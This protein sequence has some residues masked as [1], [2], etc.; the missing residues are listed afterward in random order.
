MILK[1][2]FIPFLVPSHA[3][4]FGGGF[5]YFVYCLYPKVSLHAVFHI[6]KARSYNDRSLPTPAGFDLI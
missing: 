2:E 4:F 5:K 1:I 6:L 3:K